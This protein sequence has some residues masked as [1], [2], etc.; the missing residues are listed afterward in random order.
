MVLY[1]NRRRF[2]E[3]AT[4]GNC[5]CGIPLPILVIFFCSHLFY[6]FHLGRPAGSSFRRR[7]AKLSSWFHS[8]IHFPHTFIHNDPYKLLRVNFWLKLRGRVKKT[9]LKL[10]IYL[11]KYAHAMIW[12]NNMNE[13]TT[14]IEA[15]EQERVK[16]DR[17]ACLLLLNWR[18]EAEGGGGS[19]TDAKIMN[20][21]S[22]IS[23]HMQWK[24]GYNTTSSPRPFFFFT[25]AM[26]FLQEF[27]LI[28]DI[29]QIHY[30][31]EMNPNLSFRYFSH[32]FG[33]DVWP[34]PVVSLITLIFFILII[35]I[36]YTHLPPY[37]LDS[38]ATSSLAIAIQLWW[39][40]WFREIKLVAKILDVAISAIS[41]L[42]PVLN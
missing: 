27:Q 3:E 19:W 20:T 4:G 21:P 35:F 16:L 26:W 5:P 36:F 10:K 2:R 15:H 29:F 24:M 6:Y 14:L 30:N 18:P 9:T 11:R 1:L 41:W 39:W 33:S 28:K 23:V 22:A 12:F 13:S 8:L 17:I 25:C 38:F 34:L 7:A 32:F 37:L 40:W 31:F 42:P